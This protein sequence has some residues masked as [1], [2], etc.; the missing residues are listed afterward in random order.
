VLKSLSPGQLLGLLNAQKV[1]VF[2]KISSRVQERPEPFFLMHERT[3][4][5][6]VQEE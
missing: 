5:F 1:I 4:A 6:W 2:S 3:L